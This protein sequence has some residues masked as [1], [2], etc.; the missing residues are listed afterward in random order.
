[1][2]LFIRYIASSWILLLAVQAIAQDSLQVQVKDSLL[3]EIIDTLKVEGQNDLK[4]ES[5]K[6][7][8]SI[9]MATDY[10]KLISTAAQ[11]ETK[12]ELNLGVQ[13]T[14]SIRVTADY[15]YAQ[16]APPN[17]IENG[18][19]TSSGNYFR[20]GLDYMFNIAPKTYLSLGG[21]YAMTTF[22]DEG[23]VVIES[24]VWPSLNESFVR[25][26]LK[27]NWV[28]FVI[29]SEAALLNRNEGFFT[30]LFWG[31]KFRFRF[32]I[33]RPRPEYFDVYAIPGYGQTWD[34]FIPA[35]NLFIMY[36]L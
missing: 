24:E 20:I 33:D 31:I 12:Y 35:A 27:A 11:F 9:L 2:K 25:D 18:N 22:K 15:G 8:F 1:M 6:N 36:K 23:T 26:N 29:T 4:Q 28:E 17:A 21:M 13:F 10:G 5:D 3:L 16:L 14:K 30:H 32:L 34:N 19:Y 7:Y